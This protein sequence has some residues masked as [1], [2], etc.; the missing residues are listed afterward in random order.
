M[1]MAEPIFKDLDNF[2]RALKGVIDYIE[3]NLAH[4]IQH[5]HAGLDRS[6]T[7]ISLKQCREP[8]TLP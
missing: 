4:W 1:R 2:D 7:L 6:L 5:S 3:N 8:E